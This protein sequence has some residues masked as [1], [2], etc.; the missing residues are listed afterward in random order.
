MEISAVTD[1]I[2]VRAGGGLAEAEP[3]ASEQP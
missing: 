3:A 1:T 2:D